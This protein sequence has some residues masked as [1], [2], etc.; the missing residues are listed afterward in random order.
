MRLVPSSRYGQTHTPLRILSAP[1]KG[2]PIAPSSQ[3]AN[4]RAL[5]R[6]VWC[7]VPKE[8]EM[9]EIIGLF[10]LVFIEGCMQYPLAA[11]CI[12]A[13]AAAEVL[14]HIHR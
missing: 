5:R 14:F 8:I 1:V 13:V 10:A 3:R 12:T 2:G 6:V 4:P 11:A 9:F 7:Y